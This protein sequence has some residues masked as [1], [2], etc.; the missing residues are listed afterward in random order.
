MAREYVYTGPGTPPVN[1]E[2][3]TPVSQESV[4]SVVN[5]LNPINAL[6]SLTG[7]L[8]DFGGEN[9]KG[10]IDLGE[11]QGANFEALGRPRPGLAELSAS[12]VGDLIRSIPEHGVKNK[13]QDFGT[14]GQKE[15]ILQQP[16][17]KEALGA[18]EYAGLIPAFPFMAG[19]GALAKGLNIGADIASGS[20]GATQFFNLAK[21]IPQM[22]G[23]GAV[24][25]GTSMALPSVHQNYDPTTGK[26][27][28]AGFGQGVGLGAGIGAAIPATFGAIGAIPQVW[29]GAKGMLDEIVQGTSQF[30][31]QS[32]H[33]K[34]AKDMRQRKM[35]Q[36]QM[37]DFAQQK[38]AEAAQFYEPEVIMYNKDPKEAPVIQKTASEPYAL[39]DTGADVT[40]AKETPSYEE[41]PDKGKIKLLD[42]EAQKAS[43]VEPYIQEYNQLKTQHDEMVIAKTSLEKEIATMPTEIKSKYSKDADGSLENGIARALERMIKSKKGIIRTQLEDLVKDPQIA[44][45]YAV[46]KR[47]ETINS[48]TKFAK[49]EE[50]G[51]DE[52][53]TWV[54]EEG[55][56]TDNLDEFEVINAIKEF[57]SNNPTTPN[58]YHQKKAQLDLNNQRQQAQSELANLDKEIPKVKEQYEARQATVKGIE[59]S[60]LSHIEKDPEINPKLPAVIEKPV[61]ERPR[62]ISGPE[63]LKEYDPATG[64]P[65]PIKEPTA[66]VSVNKEGNI[67]IK[68]KTGKP[69]NPLVT[70]MKEGTLTYDD[71]KPTG[72]KQSI[73][74]FWQRLSTVRK[75]IYKLS[76]QLGNQVLNAKQ[77][78]VNS[79][80]E[81]ERQFRN[82]EAVKVLEKY[83][84][85]HKVMATLG[86]VK[87]GKASIEALPEDLREVV[88]LSQ[89]LFENMTTF[90]KSAGYQT[91]ATKSGI[92]FP[93]EVEYKHL[94]KLRDLNPDVDAV[95]K[96]YLKEMGVAEESKLT[97]EQRNDLIQR[98]EEQTKIQEYTPEMMPYYKS[99]SEALQN[100]INRN[101]QIVSD[102]TLFGEAIKG[103]GK[104][105]EMKFNEL[106]SHLLASV[107]DLEVKD[108][109]RAFENVISI[110]Q[111]RG[112]RPSE[113]F[114]FKPLPFFSTLSANI[115]VGGPGTIA[116]QLTSLINNSRISGMGSVFHGGLSV[117]KRVIP[118]FKEEA[119]IRKFLPMGGM[120]DVQ[121]VTISSVDAVFKM[122]MDSRKTMGDKAGSA[123]QKASLG[124]LQFVDEWFEKE[125][126]YQTN[127][128]WLQTNTGRRFKIFEDRYKGLLTEAEWKQVKLDLKEKKVTPLVDKLI[129]ARGG[130]L[131]VKEEWDR[132]L[133][134]LGNEPGKWG[135][136]LMSYA[137]KLADEIEMNSTQLI[138]EGI[139][140]K[141]WDK[142]QTGT[143]AIGAFLATIPAYFTY[144]DWID[145]GKLGAS[146]EKAFQ[147]R[148]LINTAIQTKYP[149]LYRIL[150]SITRAQDGKGKEAAEN[151]LSPG[152]GTA[153]EVMGDSVGAMAKGGPFAAF[154]PNQNA[155]SRYLPPRVVNQVVYNMSEAK[156]DADIAKENSGSNFSRLNKIE[157][158]LKFLDKHREFART[159][160]KNDLGSEKTQKAIQKYKDD[161]N[162]QKNYGT[163]DKREAQTI[164]L[165]E[166]NAPRYKDYVLRS[167]KRQ[168][169]LGQMTRE[170]YQEVVNNPKPYIIKNIKRDR[171]RGIL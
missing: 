113:V 14:F 43:E 95:Y 164:K 160:D 99:M 10:L 105:T 11:M 106:V 153:L 6:L 9:L 41:I 60:Y 103:K 70:K 18:A 104:L 114:G 102:A 63:G 2:T 73:K 154:D 127:K 109:P 47:P 36:Q 79:G 110:F 34:M 35:E 128:H 131:I 130:E 156:I 145:N 62:F 126:T 27:N 107:D 169:E 148:N 100:R 147:G 129:E 150:D 118:G 22:M 57:I 137:V 65:V 7:S 29:K 53:V 140:E 144:Q 21:T 84:E 119:F 151:V 85:N 115:L 133:I 50:I 138:K 134:A 49:R 44:R 142:V 81:Y 37:Q 88:R 86:N 161:Y 141:N 117:L 125:L 76:K 33:V 45:T 39:K 146:V 72:G 96:S 56:D 121:D 30:I 28:M 59:D 55:V 171:E 94:G 80:K 52:L 122:L 168:L 149:Y 120:Q 16:G 132:S 82:I 90:E 58:T 123:I 17:G 111:E 78:G 75:T 77:V 143:L 74:L 139:K 91:G 167:A 135:T 152:S 66:P 89:S 13:F 48:K 157:Q 155:S 92:Y 64:L 20:L 46:G 101:S 51:L 112:F 69:E 32:D 116:K 24:V 4:A 71:I 124:P 170:K 108:I 165:F 25:G 136:K 67:V 163:V 42:L 26:L 162:R 97:P 3:T 23:V 5:A 158:D 68:T 98:L 87:S 54:K 61:N 8:L 31:K 1:F 38:Q 19:T 93:F 166:Q 12:P 40:F 83:R 15:N 159:I